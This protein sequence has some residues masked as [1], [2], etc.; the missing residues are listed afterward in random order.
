MP[1]FTHLRRLAALA[2]LVAIGGVALGLS[3]AYAQPPQPAAGLYNVF[4]PLVAR[5]GSPTGATPTPTVPTT[6]TV[7]P[8][9]PLPQVRIT[10]DA[11]RAAS[12]PIGPE[13]GTLA[14]T[15]TDGT[16]YTLVVPAEALEFTETI[17]LTPASGV[18]NLPLS[19]GLAGSVSIEPA[20]LAFDEP[21]TLT[22]E[23]G[24]APDGLFPVGFA[25]DGSGEQ[26]HFQ[27]LLD[28]P[29]PQ[30]AASKIRQSVATGRRYGAGFGSQAD[31][32]RWKAHPHTLD[33][34]DTLDES[35]APFISSSDTIPRI[36]AAFDTTILPALYAA[37]ADTS[38]ADAALASYERWQ[39]HVDT[40]NLREDFA[41]E[42]ATAIVRVLDILAGVT[43]QA[44]ERCYSQKRAEEGFRLLRMIHYARKLLGN[45]PPIVGPIQEKLSKCL[46]FKLT[47]HT[48]ITESSQ[49]YGYA[50]ELDAT[51]TLRAEPG[52]STRAVG[53]TQLKWQ[54][55]K[56][57]GGGPCGFS[58]VGESS[59]FDAQ[60][61][62]FGLDMTPVSRTSPAVNLT[63]RYDPGAPKED[64]TMSC[65]GTNPINW[66]TT[67]WFEY[68]D[69]LHMSEYEGSGYRVSSQVVNASS[70]PGWTY[71]QTTSGPSGQ[72]VVE[73]TTISIEHTPTR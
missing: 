11:T 23:R 59:T 17:T 42:R 37:V 5:G 73:D 44:A 7:P 34:L 14:I 36:K 40:F 16:R 46:A 2:Q 45:P 71:H 24:A 29:A 41:N 38:L 13:G 32:D 66:H 21:A 54:E 62:P 18:E 51:M 1:S 22:I 26:F 12:A 27:R 48:R 61:K 57:T 47:F 53:T 30:A 20:G 70:F 39:R 9:E 3:A 19:G 50:Y 63:L 8:L 52:T 35:L 65:P 56:W 10:F 31:I 55:L 6:P 43:E 60:K 25:F 28:A 64:V 15:A 49:G 72:A 58:T 69:E 33:P 68:F 4:L 67:A